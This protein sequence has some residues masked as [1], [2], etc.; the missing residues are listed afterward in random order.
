MI[1]NKLYEK[2]LIDPLKTNQ[3][4][5]LYIVSGYAS[6]TFARRHLIDT[7]EFHPKINLIIGMP[8]KKNDH[9]AFV[10]LHKQF[11]DRFNG[12]YFNSQPPVH[13]KVYSWCCKSKGVVGFSGSS[14]YSQQGFID[15][16][17]INQM[18]QD[19]ARE[20]KNFFEQL[21]Q[22]CTHMI[23]WVYEPADG[24]KIPVFEGFPSCR[25]YL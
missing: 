9:T 16:S 24:F 21:L 4:D 18:T 20:I 11:T 13:S 23:E 2:V 1:T 14:N 17:Q 6:A 8:S 25:A 3:L 7:Q 19:D 12:Y 10:E 5:E 15:G 22:K